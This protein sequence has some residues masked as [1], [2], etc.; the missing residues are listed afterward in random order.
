MIGVG[1]APL[2]SRLYTPSEYGTLAVFTATS[3]ISATFLTL[4]YEV[5]VVL[6]KSDGEA[7]DLVNL[8]ARLAVVLGI[9]GLLSV[10]VIP[11]RFRDSVGLAALG[12]FL[13]VA[14]AASVAAALANVFTSWLNRRAEYKTMSAI[15]LIQALVSAGSGISAG[16][17]GLRNGLIYAQVAAITWAAAA[18]AFFALRTISFQSA[19]PA[20]LRAAM[21]HKGA[22]LYLLPTGVLD[23]L[24]AQLPYFLITMW[25]TREDTGHYR[26]AY[27]LLAMPGALVGTAVAQVFYKRFAELWPDQVSARRLMV[28][29]W[30]VL[31]IFG[32]VPLLVVMLFGEPIFRVCLGRSWGESGII[33]RILAPMVFSSLVLSPTSGALIV[34]GMEK[35]S[36]GFGIAVMVYRPLC[37]LVGA[38]YSSLYLGLTLLVFAEIVQNVVFTWTI[39]R[40]VGM[41]VVSPA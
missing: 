28:K 23:V 40:R 22:P 30:T 5:K 11:V 3:A 21:I 32:L 13:P 36:L 39:I 26:M 1:A 17:L 9:V 27:S 6:P 34:L 16:V 35:K 29:T 33:A 31:A 41:G 24:S 37:L 38:A 19:A 25:F 14:L 7:R 18:T 15:R 4:R 8:T 12:N 10:L 2:L 20:M